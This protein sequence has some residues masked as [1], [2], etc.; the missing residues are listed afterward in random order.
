MGDNLHAVMPAAEMGATTR[1]VR[2]PEL[3]H[4]QAGQPET[5]IGRL[6]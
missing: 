6:R 5:G 1:Q 4:S 2:L 3:L